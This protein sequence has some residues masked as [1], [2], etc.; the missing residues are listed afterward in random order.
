MANFHYNNEVYYKKISKSRPKLSWMCST[1]KEAF[2]T[3]ITSA[4]NKG[5]VTNKKNKKKVK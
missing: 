5:V 4:R 3:N 2:C 1:L